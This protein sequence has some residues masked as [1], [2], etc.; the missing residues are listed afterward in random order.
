MDD[1][2]IDFESAP[3]PDAKTPLTAEAY[4]EWKSERDLGAG[5]LAG[6]AP[7]LAADLARFDVLFAERPFCVPVR[8]PD[9]RSR[10]RYYDRAGVVDLALRERATGSLWLMDHKSFAPSRW[11][12]INNVLGFDDQISGYMS[13]VS[14]VEGV[15]PVGF[16]YN[17][18][19]KRVPSAPK[20]LKNGSLSKS[21]DQNTTPE[22][23]RAAIAENKLN[24]A[25]YAEILAHLDANRKT[26]FARVAATR[27]A[28]QL[29][30]YEAD[31]ADV[32]S[33]KSRGLVYR[34]VS[35]MHCPRCP[36]RTLCE[37]D[38]RGV[39]QIG[40]GA[41]IEA[42]FDRRDTTVPPEI[43]GLIAISGKRRILSFSS[44]QEWKQCRQAAAYK[45]DGIVPKT[46][47]RYFSFGRGIHAALAMGYT[48]SEYA[49]RCTWT[50]FCEDEF[51]EAFG[52]GTE[53]AEWRIAPAATI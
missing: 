2:E 6:Y 11:S 40:M 31:F 14:Y 15:A 5:M 9:K 49:M 34:N 51:V 48:V 19:L 16:I 52:M 29:R 12:D 26:Y 38:A 36:Y 44:L 4:A 43:A 28:E 42:G 21:V 32:A 27:T 7:Q 10:S 45:E 39:D 47:A 1:V 33:E 13:A 46:T 30:K 22:L 25:D 23:Y 41:M 8:R 37:A 24:P 3:Q 18:L 20:V 35:S 17:V 50:R 53:E